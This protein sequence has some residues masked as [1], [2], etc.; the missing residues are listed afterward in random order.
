MIRK[1]QKRFIALTMSALL[2]VLV[3][4]IGSINI[5]NYRSVVKEADNILGY[6]AENDGRFP[7]DRPDS[8]D[9]F[10]DHPDQITNDRDAAD[11]DK[12]RRDMSPELPYETRFFSVLLNSQTKSI[13]SIDTGRII[14]VDSDNAASMAADVFDD[15]KVR[16]FTDDY[17]FLKYDENDSST[18]IIFL[19]CGRRLD[20]FRSFL[21]ASILVS[22][23]GFL[24]VFVIV[25]FLSN[26]IVRPISDSYEKQKTFITN[27]GHEL[28]TP[29][30]I[31]NA[32]VDVV[33]MENGGSE[34]LNDI[35]SQTK[36]LTELTNDL[37]ML[38]KMEESDNSSLMMI[39]FP[40]SDVVSEAAASFTTL[41]QSQNKKIE[42]NIRPM[43]TMKGNEKTIA[44]LVNILMDNA[45]KYSPEDSSISFDLDQQGKSIRLSVSN[46][47]LDVIPKEKLNLLFDRFYRADQSHNSSVSGHGI[48][49]SIAKAIVTAHNGKIQARSLSANRISIEAVMPN[50]L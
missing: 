48:G 15:G 41:A 39:E 17:R 16:G 14:S 1:L 46:D 35:R 42:L 24:L 43:L 40:L 37:V 6:L 23:V 22:A 7:M 19:D 13:I 27:A 8:P 29:L 36:R 11:I 38:S 34:W 2:L 21:W 33:E 25:A 5:A 3:I 18:R 32:D 49:L 47:T 50:G 44:Q 45:I 30:T 9:D 20:T 31:I 26:K 28:K 10:I 4:I 12:F